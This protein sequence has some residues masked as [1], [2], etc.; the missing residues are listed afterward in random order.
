[1]SMYHK[2]QEEFKKIESTNEDDFSNSQ[3]A[4]PN[5]LKSYL[6]NGGSDVKWKSAK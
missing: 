1:M 5:N 6:V 2:K 4:N 3:W